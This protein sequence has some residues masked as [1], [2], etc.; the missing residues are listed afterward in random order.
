MIEIP[1]DPQRPGNNDKDNG[2]GKDNGYEVPAHF[3]RSI[4]VKK[5]HQMLRPVRLQNVSWHCSHQV[6]NTEH[7]NPDDIEEMPEQTQAYQTGATE[8]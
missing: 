5:I 1:H 3:R 8:S 7:A 2:S 4:Q 6:N